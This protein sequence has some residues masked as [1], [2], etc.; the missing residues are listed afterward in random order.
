MSHRQPYENLLSTLQQMKDEILKQIKPLEEQIVHASMEEIKKSFEYES[1]KLSRCLEEIDD[2]VIK[3]N[4][5]VKQCGEIRTSLHELNEKMSQFGLEGIPVA[6]G[7]TGLDLGEVLKGR[8]EYL[9]S[10][11]KI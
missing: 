11:E 1:K 2:N 10:Q 6:D 3:C 9:R 4:E 5:C 7:L 8:I